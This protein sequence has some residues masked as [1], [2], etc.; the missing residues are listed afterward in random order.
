MKTGLILL[1]RSLCT[2]RAPRTSLETADGDNPCHSNTL[3]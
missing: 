2:D 3:T 1:V